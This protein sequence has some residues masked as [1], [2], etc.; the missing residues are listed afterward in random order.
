[1][2]AYLLILMLLWQ[3]FYIE[4][5]QRKYNK[6]CFLGLGLNLLNFK[7]SNIYLPNY[8]QQIFYLNEPEQS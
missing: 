6:M 3:F 5:F 7:R 2:F 4:T 8:L 1:M